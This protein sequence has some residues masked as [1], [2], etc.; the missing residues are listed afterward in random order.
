MKTIF[1]RYTNVSTPLHRMDPRVKIIGMIVFMVAVFL[2]YVKPLENDPDFYY[3]H[4]ANA[5][6]FAILGIFFIVLLILMLIGR[7][8]FKIFKSLK[9]M[10]FFL[11]ILMLISVF[12]PTKSMDVIYANESG[13][14]KITYPAVFS[15]FYVVIR[16]VLVL[17]CTSIVTC[18]TKPMELTFA[19]EW[20]L[21]PLKIFR[22]RVH[23][24]GMTISLAIRFIPTL[25]ED[26][27]RIMKSQASR[28]VDFKNGKLKEKF[29]SITSLIVPLF[30]SGLNK[31]SDLSEAMLARGYAPNAK[32]T[33]YRTM[34]WRISDTFCLISIFAFLGLIIAQ[35]VLGYNWIYMFFEG[36][37]F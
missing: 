23:D 27:E 3:S 29:K 33:R 28:G 18:T 1:G 30:V 12:T 16:L 7:V 5:T 17:M 34:N 20:L 4:L 32:R 11:I 36:F 13:S 10:L 14:F 19:F 22:I 2:S 9:A 24:V 21:A 37:K 31:C 25:I 15:V 35:A 8:S 6:S 26:T